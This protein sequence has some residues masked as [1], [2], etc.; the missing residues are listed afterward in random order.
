MTPSETQSLAA[1]LELARQEAEPIESITERFPDVTVGDAYEIQRAGIQMRTDAGAL[2]VG[3][4][5]GLSSKA[6]Q[7]M[8]GVNEPDYGHLLD[9]MVINT[10]DSV[11]LGELCQPR[12][13]VE[14]AYVLGEPLP[15]SGCSVADVARCTALVAASIE[16]IDSR[17][18]D[19]KI[20]LADTIADNAS[21]SRIVLS[22]HMISPAG[23]DLATLGANVRINGQLVGT[24]AAGAVL[25]HPSIAV[26]WLAN[27]LGTMGVEVTAGD[28]VLPGSCTKA[29]DVAPGDYVECRFDRLG[30]VSVSF[31]SEETTP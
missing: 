17:I 13:E 20:K 14:L 21:S 31:D 8:L 2:V 23:L 26:A 5:I 4:K 3:H 12:V 18:K 25:G 29:F 10:G 6:M 16:I 9:D 11:R 30:P 28:I 15:S 19:W 22:P 1:E 24:G 7:D 27:K